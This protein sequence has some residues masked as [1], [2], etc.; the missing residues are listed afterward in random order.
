MYVM[1]PASYNFW[2]MDIV[3]LGE[4]FNSLDAFCCKELVVNGEGGFLVVCRGFEQEY[5]CLYSTD[6]SK[7][8]SIVFVVVLKLMISKLWLSENPRFIWLKYPVVLYTFLPGD[9]SISFWLSYTNRKAG[10]WHLPAERPDFVLREIC[11]QSKGLILYPTRTSNICLACWANITSIFNRDGFW[12]ALVMASLV[13]SWKIIRLV[14]RGKLN[15]WQICQPIASPSLSSSEANNTSFAFLIIDRIFVIWCA[16][17]SICW[18]LGLK[19]S[20]I[21][22]FLIPGNSC[23]WP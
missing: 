4:I 13:I 8:C 20:S 5:M 10:V 18:N 2:Q 11:F 7:N 22:I 9:T 23:I 1:R 17:D 14:V 3:S 19:S 16:L 21:S 6:S 15:T 12:T